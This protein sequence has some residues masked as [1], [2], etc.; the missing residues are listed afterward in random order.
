[1][2]KTWGD[3]NGAAGKSETDI[4]SNDD[5]KKFLIDQLDQI[6]KANKLT[7]LERPRDIYVTSDPFSIENEILT[8]TFK[9]KRNVGRKVY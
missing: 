5:F 3:S 2:L 4:I 6:G 9:L 7:S 8:P 1:M